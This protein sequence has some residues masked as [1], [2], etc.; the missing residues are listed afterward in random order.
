[1]KV[2]VTGSK[3]F[4]GKNLCLTLRNRGHEVLEYDLGS[5]DDDL[6]KAIKACDFIVHL[7]GVNRPADIKEYTTGNVDLTRKLVD[8]VEESGSQARILLSSSIQ[9]T[10]DTPYGESKAMAEAIVNNYGFNGH[11]VYVYRLSNV[12]GKW[13]KPNY[14]SVI[15][16]FCYNIANHL[17]ITVNEKAPAIEFVYVDDV[18][19]EFIRVIEEGPT[20]DNQIH[21][22]NVSYKEQLPEIVNLLLSF[23]H[24]RDTLLVPT[25]NG[26]EKK[27]YATYLSYLPE[28]SFA[29]PL[30]THEDTRGSFT[31]VLKTKEYG[32]LSVNVI[33]PGTIKGN[34]YHMSKTEKYLVVSGTCEIKLRNILGGKPVSYVCSDKEFKIVDIVPGYAHSIK[35]IG[36]KDAVVFMWASELFDKG[37]LDTYPLNVEEENK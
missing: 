7:A 9:A 2:L 20:P 13:C 37:H 12:F 4:I 18:C 27:L 14:N 22:L 23:Q 25:Q 30:I 32:Q 36:T 19:E 6:R 5:T 10:N 1:M 17:P 28:N 24:S 35:N 26:F 33:K 34:H 11:P 8:F 15:A 29:Y 16:T 31:E 21:Y 3:G